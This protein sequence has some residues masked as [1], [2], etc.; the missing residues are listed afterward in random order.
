MPYLEYIAIGL[1]VIVFVLLGWHFGRRFCAKAAAVDTLSDHLSRPKQGLVDPLKSLFFGPK[2]EVAAIIPE[3]EETLLAADVGIET[4]TFLIDALRESK[5]RTSEE[6]YSFLKEKIQELLS[7]FK[8]E[9]YNLKSLPRPLVFFFVGVNGAG[10]TTTIGKI[11]AQYM[12]QGFRPMLVGADTFRAA[13]Q[14]QL[15]IWAE[16]CG[17]DFVGGEQDA[18]PASVVFDG[19][20]AA[21]ARGCDLV[22]IDTAGR[23]QTKSNLME[24]LKK[25]VR[26]GEKA[27][28]QPVDEVFLVLDAT[29]GQNGL[30]QARLFLEAAKVTGIILTKF[31]GTAKGGILLSVVRELGLPLRFVGVGEQIGDLKPFEAHEFVES[32]FE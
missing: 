15:K 12:E 7:N 21:K 16:R 22:L 9:P 31:D 29:V 14:D 28:Q 6:A 11:A 19:I 26:V 30:S 18:D 23:L 20:E 5:V 8:F 32:L 10:K 25:M 24:E 27:L 2:K 17:G 4:T 3:L 13:A 1:S